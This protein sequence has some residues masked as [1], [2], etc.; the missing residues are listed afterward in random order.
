LIDGRSGSTYLASILQP[1]QCCGSNS[2]KSAGSE[3]GSRMPR[4][5][6]F[7]LFNDIP[8]YTEGSLR[9]AELVHSIY[10][11]WTARFYVDHTVP[12]HVRGALISRGAE[13]SIVD[14]PS[15]GPQ[16]GRYWR[17]WVAA[18]ADVERFIVRDADSRLNVREARAVDE[19]VKSGKSFH[20]MRD[21][22]YHS[23]RILGGMWGATSGTLPNIRA[24]VDAWGH[25]SQP[26]ENDRFMS[27][28]IHPLVAEDFFSH[29]SY[30]HFSDAVPFPAHE[31]I[32]GTSFVGERVTPAIETMDVW[33]R[34]GEYYDLYDKTKA[35]LD[36]ARSE[37]AALKLALEEKQK[38]KDDEIARL[39]EAREIEFSVISAAADIERADFRAKIEAERSETAR[40]YETTR[41]LIEHLDFPAAPKSLR[42]VLPIAR[43]LR[44]ISSFTK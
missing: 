42:A 21:S 4:I 22:Y 32:S 23:K 43:L 12:E 25:Y 17:F 5:V 9:N 14:A 6:S 35:D 30:G 31:H 8:L 44:L 1:L 39:M 38:E 33:R 37:A 28:V 40:H 19:W 7:S 13:I 41:R 11:G 26:G 3:S 24:L 18:D 15:L 36:S 2:T 20:S 27:D 34:L 10:P 29:D 16:Y